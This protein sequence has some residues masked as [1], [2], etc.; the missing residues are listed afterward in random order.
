MEAIQHNHG[1]KE[2]QLQVLLFAFLMSNQE[3]T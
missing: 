2:F 3:A 1:K